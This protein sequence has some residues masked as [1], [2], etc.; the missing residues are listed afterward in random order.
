MKK[1]LLIYLS[2]LCLSLQAYAQ[3]GSVSGKVTDEGTNE[4]LIGANVILEGTSTGTVTDMDGSFT[5]NGIE[6]G[7]QTLNIT[8]LGYESISIPVT[9]QANETTNVGII[10]LGEGAVGLQEVEVIA[11][12]AIDRKTPVAVSTIKGREIEQKIGNQEFPEILRSTPSI[13]VTKQGGGFGDSRINVRGF[14]QR[15][16]AVMINGIPVNDMENGWVYWSNWAGLSDVTSS[17]QVQRGLG[18]SR[19]AIS[20]VGGTINIITDAAQ[21][22]KG[23]SV[24][25]SVGNDGYQKYGF[26]YSTG[27]GENGWA[28]T[29]QGTH[30]RGDGYV[31]GTM[32]RAWSYFASVAKQFNNQHSLHLTVVGAPQW[33]NQRSWANPITEYDQWGI[34]YNSDWGYRDGEEFSNRKNFYHKPKAF[35]NHYWTISD[36]TELAT[37]AYVSL[38][39]GGGTGDLGSINGSGIFS[40][41]FETENGILRWDDIERWNQGETVEDFGDDKEVWSNGGGFDGQYV[42]TSSSGF[43]RRASMN[44]HNW[45]GVL[46]TLTHELSQTLTLTAG[47]DGRYYKGLHYRRVENLLGAAAYFDDDDIN[48]PEKYITD[49]GRA[50]GNEI[51]YYNDGLVNWLG[52]FGQLE[53]SLNQWSIFGSFSLSN[54]GY[55]RIDYFNYLDSDPEQETDWQ[56]FFGGN[57]KAGINYNINSQH[58]VYAN[59]GYFSRQPV[60]DNVFINF[61]NEINENA[62]NE[63]V[64]GLEAGYGFRSTFLNVNLNVYRTEWSDRAI[65]RSVQGANFEGTANIEN[66]GQLHQ[67]IELDFVASPFEKLDLNGMLSLGNWTYT[68]NIEARVFDDEQNFLGSE[69]LYLEDVKVG[70]AAQTTLSVGATYEAITGLRIYGTYY[71]ADDLYADYDLADEGTFT[72]AGSQAWKL[73][74]YDLV[75]LGVSYNFPIGGLDA[76]VRV[77]VN[78]VFDEEYI[79][80][81]DT[82]ILYDPANDPENMQFVN[83]GSRANR[84]FYGFGRTW[85]AGLKVSF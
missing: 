45:F 68:S 9:V 59:A 2:L 15:N 61:V 80:E 44:E 34:K 69:T 50:E 8:F 74:A 46:S 72:E 22:K 42:N 54:Q 71:H 32:F 81:S 11:S 66:L 30:T 85:N 35:L 16:V 21:M 75:D 48:N 76:T 84:V 67:G 63:Q 12:V 41:R 83:G 24:S 3:T 6:A 43:I 13:Y 25:A 52:V 39:R 4:G 19:L 64:V 57:A 7:N 20:S 65:N 27:L 23:G 40:S 62:N 82:N 47:I 29:A 60:F 37:S 58:N 36:K 5:L 78:N 49:E 10:S 1:Y 55:K 38:G 79:S 53:Y 31:D 26:S 18:A 33:H 28:F 56:N 14:D 70:D 17:I 73:P 51:D 77:N